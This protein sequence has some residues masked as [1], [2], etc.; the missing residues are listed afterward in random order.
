MN[1]PNSYISIIVPVYNDVAYL[2]KCLD[3]LSKQTYSKELFEV[4][5]VDNGSAQDIK[6][7]VLKYEQ[8]KYA[9]ENTRGSYAARNKGIEIAKGDILG[10]TDAD[11]IPDACWIE[12]GI[13]KLQSTLN[14]G[15]VAGNIEFYFKVPNQPTPAELYDSTR[16]LQ[17]KL[18]IEQMHF[19]ATANVFTYKAVFKQVGLFNDQLKS[20]GDQEWGN[21]VFRNG[22]K[23]AYAE[24][25]Q[26][27]HPARSTLRELRKKMRRVFQGEF[28]ISGRAAIPAAT[29]VYEALLSSKP[30]LKYIW[31][32]LRDK[33][34]GSLKYRA[35]YVWIYIVVK[36]E[37]L[38]IQTKLYF[39][40]KLTNNI[41]KAV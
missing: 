25:A 19:G 38:L 29:F 21:R 18:F 33:S 31:E 22:Y 2:K 34:I 27:L 35:N 1:H 7:V 12:Q 37:R 30:S 40:I 9:L 23:L 10:F 4:I 17:Q 39:R 32:V 20:G 28:N 3:A 26:V 5:V 13:S 14:C 24:Q 6:T 16:F 8:A 11:C 41:H 36:Y 15:L